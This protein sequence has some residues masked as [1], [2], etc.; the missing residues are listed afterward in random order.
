MVRTSTIKVT[1]TKDGR[2]FYKNS[3]F[4]K[5]ERVKKSIKKLKESSIYQSIKNIKSENPISV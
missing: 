4:F 3:D 2:L 5:S 1:V